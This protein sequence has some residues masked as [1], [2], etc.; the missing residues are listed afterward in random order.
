[1]KTVTADLRVLSRYGLVAFL[2]ALFAL[3]LYPAWSLELRWF[4]VVI[5]AIV[6]LSMAMIFIS[7]F[8]DFLLILLMLCIPL[9]AFS[10]WLFVDPGLAIDEAAPVSGA[11]SIGITDF[12]LAGLYLSWFVKI[13]ITRE[14]RLPRLEGIDKWVAFY[15]I[16]V[17]LS[18]WRTPDLPRGLWALEHLVKHVMVYFYVSRHL[19]KRHL[20]WFIIAIFWAIVLQSSLGI[21]QNQTGKFSGILID[22][23]KGGEYVDYQYSVPGIEDFTRASG[24]THDSHA[25]G[26]YMA[27]LIPFTV[28]F[29]VSTPSLK[30]GY[31]L[32]SRLLFALGTMALVVTFSRSAWISYGVSLLVVIGVFLMWRERFSVPA[33]FALLVLT[34]LIAPWGVK[35]ITTRFASA[36]KDIMTARFQQFVVA[37]N[38][39]RDNL[40]FG[41]GAG[42]YMRALEVYNTNWSKNL[43][44]HNVFL[45]IGAE[46]GLLG[47]IGFYGIVIAAF[48][49]CW[50]LLKGKSDL[51]RRMALAIFAGL[52]AYVLD[53][54]TN[55]LFREAVVYMMFWFSVS[56]A[57]ALWRMDQTESVPERVA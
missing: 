26:V 53:G 47:V 42:S 34:V 19:R 44:A 5:A 45:Y 52:I 6:M 57:A 12:L 1:M 8:S 13:F 55:P 31:V 35:Y 9:A 14:Q 29:L 36:P 32:A 48:S 46:T 56:L 43:P 21:V 49:R 30:G 39:W 51:T 50:R 24:T 3:C 4:V 20:R 10:K 16:A 28:V 17:V 38:M 41:Q 23:G 7:R 18:L 37:W 40:I 2:G 15:V 22:K 11:V 33:V 54:L 27:M 25:M